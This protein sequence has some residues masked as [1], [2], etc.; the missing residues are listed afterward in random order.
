MLNGVY[1]QAFNRAHNRVGHVFQGRYKAILV[2]KESYLLELAR[3]VVLNPVRAR[4]VDAPGQW[5]WSSYR[6]MVGEEAAPEWLE[7]RAI[8][9]ALGSDASEAIGRYVRFVAE[10]EGVPSPWTQRKHQAF[11][12]SDAFVEKMLRKLPRGRDLREVPQSKAR[13]RA[14]PLAAYARAHPERDRAIAAAYASGGYT[15]QEIGDYFGLHH[16]RVSKIVRAEAQVRRKAKG[17]T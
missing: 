6:A 16:S 15:M 10:G 8:L 4:M 12:G 7:T 14:Q 17:K 5:P 3:Y 11:L 9:A 1:T 13:P 2:E